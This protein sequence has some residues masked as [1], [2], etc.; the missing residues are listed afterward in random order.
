MYLYIDP[1]IQNSIRFI[2]FHHDQEK[3]FIFEGKNREL[4]IYIVQVLDQEKVAL[5][6]I[7][8]VAVLVGSGGFSST[9]IAS[10]IANTLAFGLKIPV[11]GVLESDKP[12]LQT[13]LALFTSKKHE[14]Y[15]SP[16][17][18]GEPNIGISS[19]K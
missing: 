16:T 18:S 2:L 5:S 8:G 12:S 10:V 15:L 3:E 11:V 13:I 7:D 17:Y 19:H 6:D 4:L 9:R 14:G 1:S